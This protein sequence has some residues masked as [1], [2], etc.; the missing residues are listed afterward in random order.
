MTVLIITSNDLLVLVILITPCKA[1][2]SEFDQVWGRGRTGVGAFLPQQAP[3]AEMKSA[4]A[5][6]ARGELEPETRGG[7]WGAALPVFAFRALANPES[8]EQGTVWRCLKSCRP[9][10]KREGGASKAAFH[11]PQ[12][13]FPSRFPEEL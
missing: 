1:A 6:K 9:G 3:F 2:V 13:P 8:A 10:S 7:V 12:G 4:S 11:L 5:L